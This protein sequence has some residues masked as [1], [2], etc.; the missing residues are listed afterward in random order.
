MNPPALLAIDLAGGID[1]ARH[2]L[3]NLRIARPATSL[4]GPETLVCHSAT[5][6]HVALPPE[7]QAAMGITDGLLRVSV[8]L[9][10][11][12]DLLA[13]FRQAIPT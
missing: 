13:D 2:V 10:D 1:A 7:D 9:E 12:A 4:G 3:D 8:G 11:T 6:T 5:S